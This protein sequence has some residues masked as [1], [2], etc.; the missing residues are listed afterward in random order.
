MWYCAGASA[1][2]EARPDESPE[3]N[4]EA[5]PDESPEANLEAEFETDLKWIL[6]LK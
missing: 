3:A 4:L 1:G 2:L 6:A 5:R